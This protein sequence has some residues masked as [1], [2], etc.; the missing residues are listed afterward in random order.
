MK[1]IL[2]FLT[3]I[4][5]SCSNDESTVSNHNYSPIKFFQDEID[6]Y[7]E[8][9]VSEELEKEANLILMKD[10]SFLLGNI[11]QVHDS[12]IVVQPLLSNMLLRVYYIDTDTIY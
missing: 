5:W 3:L 4:L 2:I 12:F 7:E 9:Y 1:I 10:R 8:Q 11:E 6:Y